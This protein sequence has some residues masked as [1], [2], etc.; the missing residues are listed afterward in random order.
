MAVTI[1]GRDQP[2]A[3]E[4][5]VAQDSRPCKGCGATIF[6]TAPVA[7]IKH[8]CSPECRPRCSVE[9]CDKPRHGNTYCPAH[10]TRWKRYGDPLAPLL[11]QS[12]A[13]A[14]RKPREKLIPKLCSVDGCDGFSRQRGWCGGHYS[15]W[16]RTGKV[17]PFTYKWAAV[18][19]AC[20]I[21]GAPVQPGTKRR[22]H[23][24][25]ACQQAASR[26]NGDRP[27]SA[28]C[29]YCSQEFSL[30]SRT[31]GRLQRTDTIWCPDCGRDSPDVLRFRNYGITR[32]Q[33]AA[34]L[35]VGCLIC[36]ST[37]RKL[38][39]DHDH[40]CCPG[41]RSCGSCVRGLICGPCNR[42]LGQF[43]DNPAALIK[44]AE[45]LRNNNST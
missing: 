3:S 24:S 33:Y 39:V 2:Q 18:G 41:T 14:P 10:H 45:Y 28:V 22:K 43:G 20:E 11:R 27:K 21:C 12:N 36:E 26:T 42:G 17:Q 13:A 23:C 29:G 31:S 9:E 19:G 30:T 37:E 6:R 35:A 44:A 38:H 32:E 34:A 15:M 7:P 4:V 40:A 5:D 25:N 8:Y 1:P 16:R